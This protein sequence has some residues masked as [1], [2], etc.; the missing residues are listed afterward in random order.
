MCGISGIVNKTGNQVELDEIKKINDIIFHRGPDDEGFYFHSCFAF[1]HRRLSVIDISSSG[2]QPM[3][4]LNKYWITYN[5]E[6][7]NYIEIRNELISLGYTFRNATDTEV[8]LAA[9][10]KWGIECFQRFN[11]M[12][13][14]A[15]YDKNSNLLVLSRDRFGIKPLYYKDLE[16]AFSFG[17]E[18]K[19]LIN[20]LGENKLNEDVL[21]EYMLT[22]IDNHTE[23]TYFKNIYTLPPSH[24]MIYSLADH[25]YLKTKYY[26]LKT[27][28]EIDLLNETELIER[29]KDIFKSAVKLRL[30]SDVKIGTCLSGGLDS[31]A[32]SNLAAGMYNVESDKRFIAINAKST[33]KVNDESH[34]ASIV[35]KSSNLELHTVMPNYEDFVNSID[36]VIYTQEEPFGSPSI[37]MG[38][39]VFQKARALDCK[40]MLNG[41][42]GD[43][44]LL[45]Y[46]RYF[47]STI[48]LSNPINFFINIYKQSKKS[49]QSFFTLFAF[50]FYF[51]IAFF[52]SIKNKTRSLVKKEF[53]RN[54]YFDFIKMSARSYKNPSQLQILEIT[55]LQLPHLLRYEDRNSMRHSIEAR[56]PFLDYRLVEL[57][58]SLPL[59]MKIN[60][61]WTK[62]ILRKS[63]DE[64]LPD[65]IVWRKSK[66]GFES[67]TSWITKYSPLML[68][69]I[70]NSILLNHFCDLRK[71][72]KEYESLS[73]WDKWMYFN[74]ARWEKVFNVTL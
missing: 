30:R 10:D 68:H 21:L 71:L 49:K 72:E 19:Q 63:I 36:E 53:K 42:G 12:W 54:K 15:I 11:G 4:Y 62:Y 31:S 7:Y 61:G 55:T 35:A 13:A 67:P 28:P 23:E 5:G 3:E 1:G 74:I 40:V 39:H 17:S 24:Y 48:S 41:Q 27:I 45:G 57:A 26:E 44:I 8:V 73:D 56:L 50:Y 2:H 43:E 52:R 66:F 51:R 18:I 20:C 64:N 70:Q 60:N 9:Y 22:R 58:I 59:I 25:S 37:F 69:E 38:W 46:E 14:M 32:I 33:D 34:F 65:E 29:F 6:I 47:P 16:T